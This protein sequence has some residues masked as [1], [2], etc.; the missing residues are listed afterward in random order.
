MNYL[1]HVF[2]SRQSPEAIVGG[3]L[4]DFVKGRAVESYGP[5]IRASIELHRRIDCFTDRHELVRASRRLV[6]PE[7]RRFA[8]IMVDVFYDHFLARHWAKYCDIPLVDFTRHVYAVLFRRRASFPDRLQRI[9]PRMAGDDWLGSYRELWAIDA[10]LKG[11]A[12]RFRRSKRA[13]ALT[14][15]A[16]DIERSYPQF[17]THFLR[18]FPQLVRYVEDCG[19]GGGRDAGACTEHRTTYGSRL[20]AERIEGS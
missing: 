3:L 11:I 5:A 7:R 20:G 13:A 14:G 19:H 8:G 16:R 6:S 4:G 9:L 12:R 10:A 2:L 1:A 18:F 17:E 15:A